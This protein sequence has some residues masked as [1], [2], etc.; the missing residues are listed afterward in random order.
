LEYFSGVNLADAASQKDGAHQR[1]KEGVNVK[2]SL[3]EVNTNA[4]RLLIGGSGGSR[5]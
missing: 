3:N 1:G 5:M 2:Y 4:L